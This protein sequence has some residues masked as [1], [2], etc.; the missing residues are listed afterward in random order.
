MAF[1]QAMNLH[2]CLITQGMLCLYVAH[3]Y[4]EG[5]LHTSIK[6]YFISA[7]EKHADF[8]QI[9]RPIHPPIPGGVTPHLHQILLS[10]CLR[11]TCRFPTDCPTHSPTYT[12]RGYSTPPSN[13]TLYL[14]VRNMQ[15]SNRLPDPFTSPLAN[16][17]W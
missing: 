5:L 11:E 9:A 14:L 6:S 13:P 16:W 10:F 3:L 2:P 15:I 7:C 17:I 1:C 8:Q 4:Q 12:R